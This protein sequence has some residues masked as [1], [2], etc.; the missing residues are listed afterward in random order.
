M[1]EAKA[2]SHAVKQAKDAW[3]MATEL[4]FDM[5]LLDVGGGFPGQKSA[6]I[7]FAEVQL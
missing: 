1:E 6:P 2:F 4:G 5:T 7:T 3:D